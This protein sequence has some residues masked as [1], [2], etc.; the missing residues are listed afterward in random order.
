MGRIGCNKGKKL[1]PHSEEACKRKATTTTN[2]WMA[3]ALAV[4]NAAIM[5][6]VE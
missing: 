6:F 1:R 4:E 2:W 5:R 3:K